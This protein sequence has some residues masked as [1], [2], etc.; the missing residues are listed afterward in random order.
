MDSGAAIPLDPAR[1]ILIAIDLQG[2]RVA[3]R[4]AM[5]EAGVAFAHLEQVRA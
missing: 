4:R 5:R 3:A 2:S 1:A